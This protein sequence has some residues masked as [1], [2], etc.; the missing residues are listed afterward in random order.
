[1]RPAQRPEGVVSSHSLTRAR[2]EQASRA[3]VFMSARVLVVDDDPAVL[4]G[5]RRALALEGYD[6]LVAPDGETALALVRDQAP[7]LVVLDVLLPGLDGLSVCERL[8][9]V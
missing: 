3:E 1:M 6:V 9:A 2:A 4:S 8:R 7:D 5:L